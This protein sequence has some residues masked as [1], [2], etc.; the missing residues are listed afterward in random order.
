MSSSA[1]YLQYLDSFLTANDKKYID[2]IDVA[3]KIVSYGFRG[4]VELPDQPSPSKQIVRSKLFVK[5]DE[6]SLALSK[7]EDEI[8]DGKLDSILFLKYKDKS[9]YID[10]RD[11]IDNDLATLKPL[12]SDLAFLNWKSKFATYK[13]S[14]CAF[15]VVITDNLF[16]LRHT[17]KRYTITPGKG[18]EYVKKQ[19]LHIDGYD[20]VV[21]Y[22]I[23]RN[24]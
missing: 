3:R 2:D 6:L 7:R 20:K 22:D 4:P 8:K 24:F 21:F 10:I 11:R 15:Q 13:D 18:G 17:V 19:E 14:T 16:S 5:S 23:V 1:D 9:G 12:R